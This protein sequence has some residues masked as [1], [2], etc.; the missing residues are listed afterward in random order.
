MDDYMP[1][2][3]TFTLV[4]GDD[5][6]FITIPN[7]SVGDVYFKTAPIHQSPVDF[8]KDNIYNF[9]VTGTWTETTERRRVLSDEKSLTIIIDAQVVRNIY[10]LFFLFMKTFVASF[11]FPPT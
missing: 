8:N 11:L 4:G 3:T 2:A 10:F 7:S 6:N 1:D 9:I 5:E